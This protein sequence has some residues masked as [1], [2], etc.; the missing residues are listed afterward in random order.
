MDMSEIYQ[1]PWVVSRDETMSVIA[2]I[3]THTVLKNPL[4]DHPRPDVF[5]IAE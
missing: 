2:K 3:H 4:P 1:G 5:E